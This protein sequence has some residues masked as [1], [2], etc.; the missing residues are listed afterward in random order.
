MFSLAETPRRHAR[1][2]PEK[3]AL[4]FEETTLTY[5]DF[6]AE[7]SRVAGALAAA[8]IAAGDRVA[9]LGKNS[10][11][12]FTVTYGAAKL[13][14][15]TVGINWRLAP[16]EMAYIL[17]DA[18]VAVIFVDAEFLPHLDSLELPQKPLVVTI[19]RK[20]GDGAAD[21]FVEFGDWVSGMPGDDPGT[22]PSPDDT[23]LMVY[24]SG[25]TGRPKGAEISHRNLGALIEP[26]NEITGL[27]SES[28]PLHILPLFHIGG[29]IGAHLGLW[30]GCTNIVH[31]EV[32]PVHML[33]AIPEHR[34]TNLLM[35]PAL[36]QAFPSLPGAA[37][38]DFSS[39][40]LVLYGAS[41]ISETV[42]RAAMDL[43]GCPLLQ[44]YGLT[45]ATGLV[46]YLP[47]EDHD[48]G[49]PRAK[50]M[51]SAGK[52]VPGSEIRIVGTDGKDVA[53]GEVGEI[54]TRSHRNMKGY[55]KQPEATAAAFPE[56][57]DEAGLGWLATGD[58]GFIEDGYLF[59]HDR[60]KDLIISGGE[61]IYPA[62][63]ENVLM[64]HPGIADAAVIG[65]PSERWGE[66]PLALIVPAE[67]QDPSADDIIAFCAE[68]LARFKLPARIER[69]PEIPRNASGKILKVDLRKSY[70]EN[71]AP[72]ETDR[73]TT[74]GVPR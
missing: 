71:D 5:A 30:S 21:Q 36:L 54:W 72:E 64:S 17:E 24:T 58:A 52:P 59:I 2:R 51:R 67:G 49:G 56:G 74:D 66:S 11:E 40:E 48:P 3:P 44:T 63:I 9:F 29:G 6:H 43:F 65:V 45:E 18:D 62:E 33:A 8:G 20:G 7:S 73:K 60:V 38:T 34:V 41:P 70:W 69:L 22:T 37:E 32:D 47:P 23:A 53:P 14:A 16:P 19:G 61:N 39:V 25:T 42:M 12:F 10:P 46:T 15:A 68:R 57:R 26:F 1:L 27:H 35:V 13:G 50:R 31:R 28:V 4:V 55:W